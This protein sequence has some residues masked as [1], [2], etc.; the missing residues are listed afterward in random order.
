MRGETK[1]LLPSWQRERARRT[2]LTCPESGQKTPGS[3]PPGKGKDPWS[4]PQVY[5]ETMLANKQ[6]SRGAGPVR[7]TQ[8]AGPREAAPYECFV[9]CSRTLFLLS[10]HILPTSQP[11]LPVGLQQHRRDKGWDLPC[12]TQVCRGSYESSYCRLAGEPTQSRSACRCCASL[13]HRGCWPGTCH[14]GRSTCAAPV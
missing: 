7:D 13:A 1:Q 4:P 6:P 9:S 8:D 14:R 3:E 2:L 10:T 11:V 5:M 12:R